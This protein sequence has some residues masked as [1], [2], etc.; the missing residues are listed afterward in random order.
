MTSRQ[1]DTRKAARRRPSPISASQLAIP[2]VSTINGNTAQSPRLSIAKGA[3]TCP[4][5]WTAWLASEQQVQ[6]R[7][8]RE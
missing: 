6:S 8:R 2:V 7:Q 5:R 3:V 4:A 1:Q